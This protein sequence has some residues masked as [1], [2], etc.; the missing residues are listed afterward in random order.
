[1]EG[2]NT[3]PM[4]INNKKTHSLDSVLQQRLRQIGINPFLSDRIDNPFEERAS[5]VFEFN[6]SAYD[7]IREE[8][9]QVRASLDKKCRGV[10]VL[11]E[12][13]TGKTHLLSRLHQDL[14]K[15]NH[16]LFVPRPSNPEGILS[17]VWN[18]ILESLDKKKVKDSLLTQGEVLLREAFA[19]MLRKSVETE[20][21]FS[22]RT[23]TEWETII[24][25]ISQGEFLIDDLEKVR[26][27]IIDYYQNHHHSN[28]IHGHILRAL[29]NYSLYSDKA[30]RR[31][32]F[33]CLNNYEVDEEEAASVGLKPWRSLSED[34]SQTDILR[35][36]EQW[37]LEAVR[38]VSELASYGRPLI[39]AFDQLEGL[40][41][42]EELTREWGHGIQEIMTHCKN[43]VVVC[44]IFPSLWKNWF[45]KKDQYCTTP[46]E[47]AVVH[48]I[49]AR[50]IELD[51]LSLEKA[52]QLI[53]N[54]LISSLRDRGFKEPP[55]IFSDSFIKE[56]WSDINTHCA[57]RVFQKCKEEYDYLIFTKGVTHIPVGEDQV[58]DTRI[59][60]STANAHSLVDDGE[61]VARL[62]EILQSARISLPEN[63]LKLQRKKSWKKKVI[64]D[65]ICLSDPWNENR[66][67][68]I[69]YCNKKGISLTARLKNWTALQESDTQNSYLLLRSDRAA[70]PGPHLVSFQLIRRLESSFKYLNDQTEDLL[71]AL[72][73]TL[74]SI[75]ERELWTDTRQVN[76]RDFSQYLVKKALPKIFSGFWLN[77]HLSLAI[78]AD[79]SPA[80]YPVTIQPQPTPPVPGTQTAT[81]K[82]NLLEEVVTQ[83]APPDFS[84]SKDEAQE[85]LELLTRF[86]REYNN[87]R[88][89]TQAI[90]HQQ[91]VIAA[92]HVISILVEC[93][94]GVYPDKLDKMNMAASLFFKRNVR[95]VPI[96][97]YG[98]VC[99]EIERKNRRPWLLPQALKQ[100]PQHSSHRLEVPLGVDSLGRFKSLD[101][102]EPGPNVLIG[103]GAGS[104]KSNFLCASMASL[105]IRY[106]ASQ[107]Q[108][109][110]CDIKQVDFSVFKNVGPHVRGFETESSDILHMLEDTVSEM[111]R[112]YGLLKSEK[113]KKWS[114]YRK[115]YDDAPYLLV[116]IDEVADLLSEDR[117]LLENAIQRIAQK[118]RA[119]GIAIMLCS[120]HPKAEVINSTISANLNNRVAFKLQNH[121]QSRVILDDS[122]AEYLQGQGDC[123]VRVC[124]QNCERLLVPLFDSGFEES[125]K[126][127]YT[128]TQCYE[129]ETVNQAQDKQKQNFMNGKL[130]Q[131]G[132][133]KLEDIGFVL[134]ERRDEESF[135]DSRYMSALKER[136]CYICGTEGGRQIKVLENIYIIDI[137]QVNMIPVCN[138]CYPYLP[139]QHKELDVDHLTWIVLEK[140]LQQ[141]SVYNKV[142]KNCNVP[143]VTVRKEKEFCSNNC[144]A[145]HWQKARKL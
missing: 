126:N 74:V 22:G 40:R 138:L 42:K 28:Q 7:L 23:I 17:F 89:R 20:Q 92:P 120:Q 39:L 107:V 76:Q 111:E 75:E 80:E 21:R 94:S 115:T 123:L 99:F 122:G 133:E 139:E 114:E 131:Y 98:K 48:R 108:L 73:E 63:D 67:L 68:V 32:V 130:G 103:G 38:V 44:C 18:K 27:R 144:R 106:P 50:T 83:Y 142:C 69:G 118:G 56:M 6:H 134:G 53:N 55:N 95:I 112:R 129:N 25:K 15:E 13:G 3:E 70:H 140:R 30:R 41:S 10:L 12:A 61:W 110:I 29:F 57:R 24:S 135:Q 101:L 43:I 105:I 88:V 104:G 81:P 87:C 19:I 59:Q 119:A 72:H 51:T 109:C 64:P 33:E 141:Y 54:R 143:I 49:A 26:N 14:G 31:T 58:I 46:L 137:K 8:V 5:D 124:G 11:G 1:M 2:Q 60:R 90:N 77:K 47:D 86:T 121:H 9:A 136:R 45:T 145:K 36:R 62:T 35:G 84:V 116:V 78:I 85:C 66:D 65:H 52:V 113:V 96:V 117:D 102:F 37:A 71:T 82:I 128:E 91:D 127:A 93:E 132:I 97:E 79:R 4:E 34:S 100:M 16:M 125:F